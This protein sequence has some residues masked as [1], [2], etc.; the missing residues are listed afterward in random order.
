[1]KYPPSELTKTNLYLN[2]NNKLSYSKNE[3]SEIEFYEFISDPNKPVPYTQKE[4]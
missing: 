1:M 3:L 4:Y 2:S